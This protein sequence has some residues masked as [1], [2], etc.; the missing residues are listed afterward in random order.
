MTHT[1]YC[2]DHSV[3][4][5]N[6]SRFSHS[7]RHAMQHFVYHSS[8]AGCRYHE[9]FL[10]ISFHVD[11]P[12]CFLQSCKLYKTSEYWEI[13]IFKTRKNKQIENCFCHGN[14]VKFLFISV[15][16]DSGQFQENSQEYLR[17]TYN[18]VSCWKQMYWIIVYLTQLNIK[19]ITK[20]YQM[21]RWKDWRDKVAGKLRQSVSSLALFSQ[22][23]LDQHLL[24]SLTIWS[25][26]RRH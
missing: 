17:W 1:N 2:R 23:N 9:Q 10:P 18:F 14:S 5:N 3:K 6:F 19:L 13:Q 20:A 25:C 26:K 8:I 24:F 4:A 15:Q 21:F 16:L 11:R 7:V 12:A 22:T